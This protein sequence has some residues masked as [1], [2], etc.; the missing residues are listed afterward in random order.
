MSKI[1]FHLLFDQNKISLWKDEYLNY[2]ECKKIIKELY[3]LNNSIKEK[4]QKLK[5]TKSEREE[6]LIKMEIEEI[7]KINNNSIKIENK[8]K[9][10]FNTFQQSNEHKVLQIKEFLENNLQK[11]KF[12]FHFINEIHNDK[13]NIEVP[14]NI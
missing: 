8:L 13:E 1:S 4:E 12:D 14:I 2:R 6:E 11:L 5:Q 9:I 10:E 3:V 7:S